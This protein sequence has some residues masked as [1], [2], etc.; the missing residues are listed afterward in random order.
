MFDRS[1]V[2]YPR[3][4]LSEGLLVFVALFVASCLWAVYIRWYLEY[5]EEEDAMKAHE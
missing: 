3:P 5:R 1:W 2:G 4:T